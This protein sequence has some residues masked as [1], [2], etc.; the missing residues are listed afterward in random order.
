M[1]LQTLPHVTLVVVKDCLETSRRLVPKGPVS[2]HVPTW[3]SG[4]DGTNLYKRVRKGGEKRGKE[5]RRKGGRERK[6]G[7][8]ERKRE[9]EGG[10]MLFIAQEIGGTLQ[11]MLIYAPMMSYTSVARSVMAESA[12]NPL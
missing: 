1:G 3:P 12:G 7:E 4:R 9:R 2:S 10:E 6:E 11:A 8:K 5:R